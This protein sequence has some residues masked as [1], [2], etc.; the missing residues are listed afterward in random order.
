MNEIPLRMLQAGQSAVVSQL[1]GR[2]DQV[3]RLQELGFVHGTLVE[4]IQA[5]APCIL[6]IGERKLGFRATELANVLVRLRP[7]S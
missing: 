7:S 2:T 1:M 3:Q 4:M 6:R 5:G